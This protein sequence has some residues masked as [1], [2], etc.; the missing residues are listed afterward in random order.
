MDNYEVGGVKWERK[1]NKDIE[2][3]KQ[4]VK[5]IKF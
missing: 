2:R 4:K 5:I 3:N 1:E